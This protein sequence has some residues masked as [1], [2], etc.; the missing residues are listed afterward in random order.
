M[1]G[2]LGPYPAYFNSGLGWLG[3]VPEHWDVRRNKLILRQVD[4]RSEYGSEDLLS[5]SQ[6]TGVTRRREKLADSGG[7]LTNAASL[8]GYKRVT[9]DDLVMNIMLAW[10]GSL[11]VSPVEGIVSPAY[12]VFRAT[13]GVEPRYLHYLLRTPL[14]TGMFKTVSTGVVDS[15]LRLY[16]DVFLRLPTLVPPIAEQAA[17]VRFLDHADRRIRRY[18]AAKRR[19]IA[20]LDEQKQALVN[21][22][23]CRDGDLSRGVGTGAVEDRHGSVEAWQF[24]QLR[25]VIRP[26]TTITYGIVQA[27]PDIEGG[28]PYI[29]TS[30]MKADGL[31]SSGYLRTSVE[32]D[33]A[34]A[35]SKVATDDLVVAI[36]A[37]LGRGLLVPPALDGANLTQGTA[38]VSPGS[39]LRPRYL[40]Y[41]FNSRYC[42]M[43]VEMFAKGTT[44]LEITLESLRKIVVPVPQLNEQDAIVEQLDERLTALQA[45]RLAATAQ[46]RFMS[47][48][49][50]RLVSDVV[51]GR[52]DV[53]EAA[54]RL[55]DE[56]AGGEVLD[57][58]EAVEAGVLLDDDSE[59][60]GA[61]VESEA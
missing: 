59:L 38:R 12:C 57:I 40:F 13:P 48:Y 28:I 17:I 37:S 10:N 50:T 3:D 61:A 46:V 19:L 36:R 20:L 22:I 56:D 8:V 43:Q 6:Y 4:E 16:P 55:R 15:R 7:L 25:W 14:F 60:G 52:L 58:G 2:G 11:G 39:R 49:R 41:A 29:R 54:A 44:F 5:V 51:T 47:E 32:I 34:Y 24:A 35:R 45:A 30:D 33:R 21:R 23:A 31:A 1:I 53:R 27:G 26:G 42:Q 18:I 9:P